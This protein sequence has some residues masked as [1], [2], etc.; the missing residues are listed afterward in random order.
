MTMYECQF[1]LHIHIVTRIFIIDILHI[2]LDLTTQKKLVYRGFLEYVVN[3]RGSC[4]LMKGA[5]PKGKEKK[6]VII[7][8]SIYLRSWSE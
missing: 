8:I 2:F 7:F 1:L 6:K 3:A 5:C 4:F